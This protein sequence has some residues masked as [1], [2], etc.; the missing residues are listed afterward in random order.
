MPHEMS[1][2]A[3]A[4]LDLAKDDA[5]LDHFPFAVDGFVGAAAAALNPWPQSVTRASLAHA[6]A[7]QQLLLVQLVPHLPQSFLLVVIFRS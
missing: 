3:V 2:E 1:I 5:T 6:Q 7:C 4:R